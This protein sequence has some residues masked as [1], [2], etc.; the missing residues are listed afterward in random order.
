[1]DAIACVH[2]KP[3][4]SSVF[5]GSAGTAI[6]TFH[7][8]S[9]VLATFSVPAGRAGLLGSALLLPCWPSLVFPDLHQPLSFFFFMIPFF[10][11]RW[12]VLFFLLVIRVRFPPLVVWLM[13]VE[14]ACLYASLCS[15][16]C[17]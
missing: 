1:V 17:V 9:S 16:F 3:G 7:I 15:H 5:A 6:A 13:N 11:C 14:N 4:R 8:S 12:L 10:S 2:L